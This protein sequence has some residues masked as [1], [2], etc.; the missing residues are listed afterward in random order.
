[1]H[2]RRI[3]DDEV[4]LH[5]WAVIGAAT[6]DLLSPAERGQT[7]REIASRLHIAPDGSKRRYSR[8]TID[9]WVRAWRKEGIAGLRP[10]PRADTGEIRSHPELFEVAAKLRLEAPTRSSAQIARMIKAHYGVAVSERTIRAQ[11]RRRGLHREAL[12]AEAKVFGRY[13][14]SRPNERWITDVL[15]GPFVPY[16]KVASSVKAKLFLIVD[17]HSRLIVDGRFFAAENARAAQDILQRAITH[18]GV[19]DILYCDNG[20]PFRNGWLERTCAMLGIRLVHSK[21]YAP[22]GRGKQ[23]RANRYIRET[24]LAEACRFEIACLEDLNEGF[25][26]W[27]NQEANRRIHRE[28]KQRPIDRFEAGGPHRSLAPEVAFEAFRWSDMRK[29]TKTATVSLEGNSYSVDPSLVGRRVELRYLP[30]DLARID[31]FCEGV[32]AG[33]AVAFRTGRHVARVVATPPALK[34]PATNIDYVEMMIAAEEAET[35]TGAKIDF[36]QLGLFGI[37][38]QPSADNDLDGVENTGNE[39]VAK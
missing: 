38:D 13:E 2:T 26:A 8:G 30:E 16:P 33:R 36:T 39:E 14:A 19:P 27:V 9:R 22:Q 11:L 17:D 34:A 5:R 28:T 4:A 20:A 12:T 3:D 32:P 23:E 24:F 35:G 6:S 10:S 7:V 15:V 29:V 1:M 25:T 21:P 31:V 18:R 37:E